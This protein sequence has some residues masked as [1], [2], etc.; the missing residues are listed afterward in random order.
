VNRGAFAIYSPCA[1]PVIPMHA[2]R[3]KSLVYLA[4]PGEGWGAA[5]HGAITSRVGTTYRL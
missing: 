4:G 5:V 3:A 2:T 1:L